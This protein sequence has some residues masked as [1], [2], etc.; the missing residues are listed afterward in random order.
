MTPPTCKSCGY[1]RQD[2]DAAS[3]LEC[4]KCRMPYEWSRTQ[5]SDDY[6]ERAG[7]D[8][9]E[10]HTQQAPRRA[11]RPR[12]SSTR[13]PDDTTAPTLD[14][15][16][17]ALVLAFG[18]FA[19]LV[20]VPIVGSINAVHSEFSDGH[21]LLALAAIAV[22]L[23]AW[24]AYGAMK[25]VGSIA[26]VLVMAK[27]VSTYIRIS[28]AKRDLAAGLEGN[29]FAGLAQAMAGSIQLEWGWIPLFGGAVGLL[30]V[31][32]GYRLPRR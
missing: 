6:R 3:A 15:G 28:D 14:A 18:C 29:P 16:I 13:A 5:L 1:Q 11:Y 2:N 24:R 27:A 10:E 17:A 26:F 30:A 21:I 4:P 7:L 19:P 23:A 25:V 32:M 9:P 12:A 8:G 20:R 31:S 22:L